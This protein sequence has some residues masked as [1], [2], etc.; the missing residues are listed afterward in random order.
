MY[1]HDADA[2][3]IACTSYSVPPAVEDHVDFNTL[4]L[5]FDVPVSK[6]NIGGA[7]A[8]THS[9]SKTGRSGPHLGFVP[10]ARAETIPMG[11]KNCSQ[12]TTPEC[13]RALYNTDYSPVSKDNNSYGIVAHAPSKFFPSDLDLF[14]KYFAPDAIGVR[15]DVVRLDGGEYSLC[16]RMHSTL[17]IFI[18]A[19]ASL[20][21]DLHWDGT[22]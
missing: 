2:L 19:K 22:P 20:A 7:H 8:K 14:A 13:L 6:R 17:P 10:G 1:K 5:Q 15:P 16:F 21:A 11:L 9:A 18:V 4:T 12:Q 3:H